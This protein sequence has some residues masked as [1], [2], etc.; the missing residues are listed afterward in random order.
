MRKTRIRR[1][2]SRR[3]ARIIV[4]SRPG[5]GPEHVREKADHE[6]RVEIE[7]QREKGWELVA[8]LDSGEGVFVKDDDAVSLHIQLPSV[9]YKRLDTIATKRELTKRALVIAA[10]ELYFQQPF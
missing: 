1:L 7:R 2:Y 6:S 10:L 5:R 8:K 4:G 3:L 9:L